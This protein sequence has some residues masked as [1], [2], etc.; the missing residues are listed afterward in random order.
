[1]KKHKAPGWSGLV[2]KMIQTTGDIGTQW[3]YVIRNEIVKEGSI[4]EDW[5]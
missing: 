4:P 5:K 1:M 3:T 2:S